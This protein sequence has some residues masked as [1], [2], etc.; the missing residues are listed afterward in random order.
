V[1][2]TWLGY[3]TKYE[4]YKQGN[5]ASTFSKDLGGGALRDLGIY[6]IY[7]A[8]ELFGKPNQVTHH[9]KLLSTGADATCTTLL[10]YTDFNATLVSSKTATTYTPSEIIG[11]KGSITIEPTFMRSKI[12]LNQGDTK[13]LIFDGDIVNDMHIQQ[14]Q[15]LDILTT[16]NTERINHAH[17]FMKDSLQIL[18]A[19]SN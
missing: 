7:T 2:F 17:T 1:H 4:D 12:Y 15:L 14:V 11:E 10:Q 13:T 16:K 3:S 8:L 19:N 6:L 9:K 18:N 5:I